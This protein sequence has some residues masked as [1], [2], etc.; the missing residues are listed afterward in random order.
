MS[1]VWCRYRDRQRVGQMGRERTVRRDQ[2]LRWDIFPDSLSV[3]H[4][5]SQLEFSHVFLKVAQREYGGGNVEAG[6]EAKALARIAFMEAK[7]S[8][9]QGCVIRTR[10]SRRS[11]SRFIR[12][13]VRQVRWLRRRSARYQCRIT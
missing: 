8:L 2:Q 12:S 13:Q 1:A 6:Q 5:T 11:A 4:I 7:R 9:G 10:G 3:P